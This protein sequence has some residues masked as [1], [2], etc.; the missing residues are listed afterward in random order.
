MSDNKKFSIL[1]VDD[2]RSNL[3]VLMHILKPDYGVRIAKSGSGALKVARE[4]RPDLILLDVIMPDM[5]GFEVLAALKD[6]DQ[7]R[8]IPVIFV[9]GLSRTEDEEQGFHAG[10]VDYIVKPFNHA[11]VKARVATQIKIIRQMRTIERLRRK[12]QENTSVE[13]KTAGQNQVGS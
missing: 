10:A 5:T 4:F 12:I 11:V 1:I 3:D 6:S 2:E 7:T 9:T 8:D 13:A